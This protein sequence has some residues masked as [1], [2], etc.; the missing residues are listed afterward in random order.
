MKKI[1]KND[2]IEIK[3]GAGY[4]LITGE[5]EKFY[6]GVSLDLVRYNMFNELGEELLIVKKDLEKHKDWYTN[7]IDLEEIKRRYEILL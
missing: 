1:E 4:I 6:K 7:V 3:N 5:D 2:V